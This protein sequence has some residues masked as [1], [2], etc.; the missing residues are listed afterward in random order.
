MFFNLVNPA[1]ADAARVFF[2]VV[3]RGLKAAAS[4]V[5]GANAPPETIVCD[6]DLR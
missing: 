6:D 4:G 2:L 5:A 3:D 1:A